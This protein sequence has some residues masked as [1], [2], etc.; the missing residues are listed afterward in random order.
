MTRILV[1]VEIIFRPDNVALIIP[2][3]VKQQRLNIS[4]FIQIQKAA[5]SS[6]KFNLT[7]P[8]F[9]SFGTKVLIR[10]IRVVVETPTTQMHQM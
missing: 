6:S 3:D 4:I 1:L 9:Y 7:H 10:R 5:S 8:C 2:Q